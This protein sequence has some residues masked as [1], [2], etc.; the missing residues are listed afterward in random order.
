V[1]QRRCAQLAVWGSAWL[2]GSVAFDDALDAVERSAG[3]RPA[4]DVAGP[5][6]EDAS[7]HPVGAA[8]A[9]WRRAG[10]ET[11]RLVLPVPG[12]VRGLT[13]SAEFRGVALTAGEAVFGTGFGVTVVAGRETP[14]SAGRELIWHRS[15]GEEP[16]PDPVSM[17]EAEHELTEAIRETASELG[18]RGSASWM[19][20]VATELS[21]ARRAGE[22]LRLPPSHPPR[23]VRLTAQA[24]RLSAVLAM[25]DRDGTGEVTATGMS[26][27][28][29]TLAPLRIAVRR[30]LLAGY[31]AGSEPQPIRD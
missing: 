1:S 27:R 23:A 18:R 4:R 26:E 10:A 9:G 11:L 13:G 22:R 16:R 7:L 12:D 2:A 5:G 21:D 20:D 31:N 25:V 3:G 8:L 17:S 6:F 24:E 19:S 30:A 14:S 29:E 28:A 15:E